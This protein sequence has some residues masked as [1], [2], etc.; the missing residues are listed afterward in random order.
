MSDVERPATNRQEFI[1][2]LVELRRHGAMDVADEA[3]LVR[4]YDE[5]LEELRGEKVRLEPEYQRRC[6]DDGRD[7]AD[8]WLSDAAEA[9][10]RSQGA[11][12]R[13]LM[14]SIPAIAAEQ[15]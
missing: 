1:E 11:R 8:A 2:S 13:A 9:L 15:D 14:Q 3:A 4:Q 12:V 6:R 7:A 10:G 5:L